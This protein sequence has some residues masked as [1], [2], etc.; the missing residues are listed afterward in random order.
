MVTTKH[1]TDK[2]A[3]NECDEI[4]C[5]KSRKR[6]LGPDNRCCEYR[7]GLRRHWDS[8][9]R[10]LEKVYAVKFKRPLRS[11][12]CC[13]TLLTGYK[14][15]MGAGLSDID[16]GKKK[17]GRKERIGLKGSRALVKKSLPVPCECMRKSNLESFRKTLETPHT[18]SAKYGRYLQRQTAGLFPVGWDKRY[19]AQVE[20][21]GPGL[22]ATTTSPRGKG[23]MMGDGIGQQTY[24]AM[25]E[26]RKEISDFEFKY[27]E[28]P[29]AGK[30]RSLT[31]T[32]SDISAFR[33]LHKMIY[34]KISKEKWLLRG[35]PSPESFLQAGFT[36]RKSILSGDYKGATDSLSVEAAEIILGTILRNSSNIPLPVREAALK[37]LRPTILLP[38]GSSVLLRRGQ[39]MGSLLSFPLLCLQNRFA[40][41]FSLGDVPMLINGDD[42]VA[43]CDPEAKNRWFKLLPDLGLIPEATKTDYSRS[44]LTINSTFFAIKAGFCEVVPVIRVKMLQPSLYPVGIGRTFDEFLNYFRG[45]QRRA[46]AE[47]FLARNSSV[48]NALCRTMP[49]LGFKGRDAFRF[50]R[51]ASYVR[52]DLK[53]ADVASSPDQPL[54]PPLPHN[55]VLS[56]EVPLPL[57]RPVSSELREMSCVYNAC[58]KWGIKYTSKD[59]KRWWAELKEERTIKARSVTLPFQAKGNLFGSLATMPKKRR[60]YDRLV[61]SRDEAMSL[62]EYRYTR[63]S[64]K[65]VETVHPMVAQLAPYSPPPPMRFIS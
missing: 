52:R 3:R 28:V 5:G 1:N 61:R 17:L 2:S 33:P 21:T 58:E 7:E 13:A 59:T 19:A 32:G 57:S 14:E 27:A 35:P 4:P 29:T 51:E 54:L 49:S 6:A 47:I 26:G 38:D 12:M 37:A 31:I 65:P 10:V 34:N 18:I 11:Q 44:F 55:V 9:M 46:M 20:K 22:G 23:G 53:Y 24:L 16:T 36:F 25:C 40:S 63:P 48:I 43:E 56:R 45:R 15:W 64:F 50:L 39:M 8:N 42:L 62:E 30:L 41:L 60:Y